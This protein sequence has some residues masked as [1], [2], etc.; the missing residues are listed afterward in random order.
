[1]GQIALHSADCLQHATKTC[2]PNGH[3]SQNA[4]SQVAVLR[5]MTAAEP[6]KRDPDGQKSIEG[7]DD[8]QE[9]K[10]SQAQQASNIVQSDIDRGMQE[11]F[12]C[13]VALHLQAHR[14]TS[15]SLGRTL[16]AAPGA[17]GHDLHTGILCLIVRNSVH[18]L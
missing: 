15:T 9:I 17:L 16:E 12:A 18:I 2:E 4:I 11:A 14:A 10:G 13:Q 7:L 3:V 5:C 6:F 8:A 1:M